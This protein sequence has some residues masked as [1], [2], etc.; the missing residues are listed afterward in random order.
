MTP[1]ATFV[2]RQG[3]R[4][5]YQDKEGRADSHRLKQEGVY[6]LSQRY[7]DSYFYEI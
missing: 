4:T 5:E 1:M 3:Y 7:I 6:A 2:V